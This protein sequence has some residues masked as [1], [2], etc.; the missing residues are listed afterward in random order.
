MKK[1]IYIVVAN[2]YPSISKDLIN[3]ASRVLKNGIKNYQN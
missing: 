3:G 1:K 2:Y